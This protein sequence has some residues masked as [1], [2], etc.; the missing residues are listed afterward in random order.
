[1]P[2]Q[3]RPAG[4][5]LAQLALQPLHVAESRPSPAPGLHLQASLPLNSSA[6]ASYSYPAPRIPGAERVI[7]VSAC[8]RVLVKIPETVVIVDRPRATV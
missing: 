2:L 5:G 3:W 4:M 8:L 7:C 6:T 1:V